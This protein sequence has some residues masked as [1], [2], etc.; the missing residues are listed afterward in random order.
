M[1]Q[2]LTGGVG[3]GTTLALWYQLLKVFDSPPPL[4]P[5]ELLCPTT[6]WLDLHLPSIIFGILIGLLIGPLLEA[7]VALRVLIYH[8]AI[9]RVSPGFIPA[10]PRP[11]YR[12]C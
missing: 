6:H 4:P 11:L 7:I 8:S 9:R 3:A 2:S 5:Y 10:G 1:S 12:I